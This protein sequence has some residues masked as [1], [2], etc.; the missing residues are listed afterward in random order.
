MFHAANPGGPGLRGQ[1]RTSQGPLVGPTQPSATDR[2]GQGNSRPGASELHL[3]MC[4]EILQHFNCGYRPCLGVPAAVIMTVGPETGPPPWE[5]EPP[6]M[7]LPART[8]SQ[9]LT[10]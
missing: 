2:E 4:A 10:R 8:G 9:R 3:L 7:K 5:A 1:K 6:L